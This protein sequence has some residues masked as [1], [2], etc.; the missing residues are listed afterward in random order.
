MFPLAF[1]NELLAYEGLDF[2]AQCQIISDIGL[3]GIEIA[4]GTLGKNPL[5]L[6]DAEIANMREAMDATGLQMTGLHWLLT[7]WPKLSITDASCAKE[8]I[9]VLCGL[10]DLCANL[11][12]KVMVHGSPQQRVIDPSD[13][14]TA[15]ATAREVF[16]PVA[17]HAA[18]RRLVYCIEPLDPG[19]TAFVNTVAQG[20]ELAD[21]VASPAFA[22]MID[23]SSAHFSESTSVAHTIR[24]WLP[25]GMIGHVHLNDS[26]RGAP[27]MGDDPFHDIVRAI[28]SCNW[29]SPVT[30][31]PFRV[32]T[33]A[34]T[35]ARIGHKTITDIFKLQETG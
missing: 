6:G 22:T 9:A 8:T 12:G 21:A 1:C 3:D 5:A 29:N 35:T 4:P 27:G 16:K 30:I 33:D 15:F 28:Q 2:K 24:N 34:T 18:Q 19:Q 32:Q 17:E 26:N 20:A 13:Y 25:S 23:T 31:E 11:G 10:V 14:A 7:S